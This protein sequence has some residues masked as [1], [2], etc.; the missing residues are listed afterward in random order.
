[1]AVLRRARGLAS[2]V[3][4]LTTVTTVAAA[5]P[6]VPEYDLKAAFLYNFVKFVDWPQDAFVGERTPLTLCVFGEDP[7]GRS[8]DAVVR[9]ER[10]GERELVVQRTDGLDDLD[11]C[12]VL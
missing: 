6:D 9:G 8:L 4:L 3:L 1:M 5:Q 12:H 7:F 11:A 10:V 2:I